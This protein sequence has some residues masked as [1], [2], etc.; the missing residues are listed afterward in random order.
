MR[1]ILACV[2]C[3]FFLSCLE[4]SDTVVKTDASVKEDVITDASVADANV[5][6]DSE[7]FDIRDA[8]NEEEIVHEAGMFDGNFNIWDRYGMK[9]FFY[10][11]GPVITSP[12]NLHIIWYGNWNNKQQ[13]VAILEDLFSNIGGSQ[14]LNTN[15]DYYQSSSN[16]SLK[17]MSSKSM[18][19]N[20]NVTFAE[21]YY[22]NYSLGKYLYQSDI[23]N[24]ISKIANKNL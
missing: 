9:P 22:D 5:I 10:R 4:D 15:A 6:T 23:P 16:L 3:I 19:V 11:G 2:T 7:S 1:K 12:S 17:P 14:Y 20:T 21:S 18:F 8:G 24:I 13:T